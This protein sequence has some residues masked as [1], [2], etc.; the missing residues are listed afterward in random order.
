MSKEKLIKYLDT[1]ILISL[2]VHVISSQFLIAISSIGQGFLIGL[3]IIRLAIDKNVY[4]PEKF[5]FFIFLLF[6]F[7]ELLSSAFSISPE[8]S[9]INSKR[10]SLFIGFFAVLIFVKDLKQLKILLLWLFIFSA[11]LSCY[12][13]IKYSI[14]FSSHVNE[15]LVENRL[16]YFGY[17]ITNGEIKMLIL[18]LIIPFLFIKEDFVIKKYW[19]GIIIIPIFI[20]LFLTSSRN[21]LLGLFA[22]IIIIGFSKNKKFLLIFLAAVVLF[23]IFAPMGLK[24]RILSIVDMNHPSNQS[25]FV[26]WKT[27][28]QIIKDYFWIGIGDTDLLLIYKNYKIPQFHGEGVHLHNNFFQ[29]FLTLGVVGFFSYMLMMIYLIYRQ[30]KIYIKTKTNSL[31]N[32]IAVSSLACMTAFHV[33]GLT[34][35]NFGDFEFAALLWFTLGLAFLSEKLYL[36][37][38][39]GKA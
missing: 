26:M 14:E 11:L 13:L 8:N 35:W 3:M 4:M 16:Q 31:L 33:S 1:G 37:N 38:D 6:I 12:E 28:I 34:E 22:G 7:C 15:P 36:Q 19:L 9:F 21:A 17:P 29:I 18:L 24:D 30:I 5:L 20:T 10:V 39:D 2:G 23:L 25:R 32:I 27:G